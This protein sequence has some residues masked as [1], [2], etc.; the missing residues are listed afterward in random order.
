MAFSMLAPPLYEGQAT[1]VIRHPCHLGTSFLWHPHLCCRLP[2]PIFLDS[3]HNPH[4]LL[5]RDQNS[6]AVAHC[7]FYLKIVIP[8][9]NA[10]H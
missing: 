10:S 5:L 8:G 1:F 4:T 3:F 6:S 9:N 2:L 7:V